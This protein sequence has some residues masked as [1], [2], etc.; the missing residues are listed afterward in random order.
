MRRRSRAQPV[1]VTYADGR[2]EVREPGSFVKRPAQPDAQ[3]RNLRATLRRLS[4]AL[5]EGDP[6]AAELEAEVERLLE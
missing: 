2:T 6:R 5:R 3:R 4:W 1:T